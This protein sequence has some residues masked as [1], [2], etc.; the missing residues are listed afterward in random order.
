MATVKARRVAFLSGDSAS[1]EDCAGID[2]LIADFPLRGACRSVP[3]RIDRFDLWR[4]GAHA[5]RI[6]GTQIDV[7]NARSQQGQRPWVVVPEA[8][9]DKFKP[10][11]R[12]SSTH[13][14]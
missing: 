8:R 6:A 12:V 14:R 13:S 2:I 1:P 11:G 4:S 5:I 10:G 3:T 7:T 9:K